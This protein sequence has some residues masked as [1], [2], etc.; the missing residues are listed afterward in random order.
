MRSS[1]FP[2]RHL[3]IPMCD[4]CQKQVCECYTRTR[5]VAPKEKP[6]PELNVDSWLLVQGVAATDRPAEK[7]LPKGLSRLDGST[8]AVMRV[9]P[10]AARYTLPLRL[11][12]NHD[13]STPIGWVTGADATPTELRFTGRIAP[14]GTAGYD[15]ALLTRI[16]ADVRSGK[17]RSLSVMR[18]R[19]APRGAHPGGWVWSEL[20]VVESP[21]NPDATITRVVSP[22]GEDWTPAADNKP[23][24]KA[25]R[26]T[27][28]APPSDDRALDALK[29]ELDALKARF[30]ERD[31]NFDALARESS[32]GNTPVLRWRGIWDEAI[33]YKRGEVVVDRSSLWVVEGGAAPGVRPGRGPQEGWRLILKSPDLRGVSR[34]R[35]RPT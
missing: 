1:D 11:L 14:P 28:A 31:D 22:D 17:L 5:A 26:E 27:V 33:A 18:Q 24:A 20:S 32:N 21:A 8:T 3:I 9:D 6:K 10:M 12:W 16:W 23:E 19:G 7:P 35:Y 34:D 25:E 29:A 30:D 13:E 2:G 15:S 4:A